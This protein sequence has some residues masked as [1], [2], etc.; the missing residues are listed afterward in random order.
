MLLFRTSKGD[1]EEEH[2]WRAWGKGEKGQYG[3]EK[4]PSLLEVSHG[5]SSLV[6]KSRQ[7]PGKGPLKRPQQS[8]GGVGKV[9]QDVQAPTPSPGKP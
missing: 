9:K 3:G 4:Q 6:L 2:A 1:F 8:C 7:V 5:Y